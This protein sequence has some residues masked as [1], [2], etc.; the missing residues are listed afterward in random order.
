MSILFPCWAGLILGSVGFPSAMGVDGRLHNALKESQAKPTVLLFISHDCPICNTYAPAIERLESAYGSRASFNL[1]YCD[2]SLSAGEAKSHARQFSI[3]KATL[4]LDPKC[5]IA[6]FCGATVTPQAVVFDEHARKVY[7]GRID[8][9]YIALGQQRR[10]PKS[11][12]LAKA[13][14]A[15]LVHNTPS[16]ASGPPVG[17]Y[18]V[19]PSPS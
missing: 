5:R 1:V 9:R 4:L 3:S 13:L 16:A 19:F 2:P 8:D 7:S 14:D 11:R 18:I 12:D 17:C 6:A 15:V 10:F